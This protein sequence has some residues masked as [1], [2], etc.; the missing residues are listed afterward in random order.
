M[1]WIN[2]KIELPDHNRPVI[3]KKGSEIAL[4]TASWIDGLR[5]TNQELIWLDET[6]F[7]RFKPVFLNSYLKPVKT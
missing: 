5:S 2:A 7:N 4:G 1:K 3:Y 6:E